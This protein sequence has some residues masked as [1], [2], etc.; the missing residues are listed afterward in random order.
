MDQTLNHAGQGGLCA[1]AAQATG[2]D[3]GLRVKIFARIALDEEDWVGFKALAL[4]LAVSVAR[5][6][7]LLV[8]KASW[9]AGR[10]AL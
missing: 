3:S 1:S 8:E 5:A 10:N 4:Q 7:G 9:Q 2:S 6:V